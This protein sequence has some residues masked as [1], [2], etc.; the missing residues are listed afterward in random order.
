MQVY[1]D[2][3]QIEQVA[4]VLAPHL[5]QAVP[6]LDEDEAYEIIRWEQLGSL[7]ESLIEDLLYNAQN[8]ERVGLVEGKLKPDEDCVWLWSEL[9]GAARTRARKKTTAAEATATA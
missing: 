4:R 6:G 2:N 5:Q 1:V 3:W 7:L 8:L 9:V